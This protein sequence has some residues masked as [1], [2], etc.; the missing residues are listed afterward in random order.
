MQRKRIGKSKNDLPKKIRVILQ[1]QLDLEKKV[2]D[3]EKSFRQLK[4]AFEEEVSD[5]M[6]IVRIH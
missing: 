6:P 1:N 2:N 5:R 4:E 3:L